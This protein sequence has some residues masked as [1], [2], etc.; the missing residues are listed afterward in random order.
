MPL[1][2]RLPSAKNRTASAKSA[3]DVQKP[4]E[5]LANRY[6]VERTLGSGNCGTALLV[7]DRK[8]KDEKE[9]LYV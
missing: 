6:I 8:D 5:T 2:E 4:K 7:T 1:P 3:P 9:K